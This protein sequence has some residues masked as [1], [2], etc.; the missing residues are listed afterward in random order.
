[1]NKYRIYL[2]KK[3]FVDIEAPCPSEA[4]RIAGVTGWFWDIQKVRD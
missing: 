3:E 1:M 2:S 4:L